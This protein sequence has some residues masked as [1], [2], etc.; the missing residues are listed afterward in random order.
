MN[1]ETMHTLNSQFNQISVPARKFAELSL[2]HVQKLAAFQLDAGRNYLAL[3]LNQARSAVEFNDP[4]GFQTFISGQQKLLQSL[5]Q[6]LGE[7]AQTVAAYN[8]DYAEAAINLTQKSAQDSAAVAAAVTPIKAVQTAVATAA[9]AAP[10]GVAA[11]V[12]TSAAPTVVAS[13]KP[14]AAVSEP[15][16]NPEVVTAPAR[17]AS[18]KSAPKT[19]A[20]AGPKATPK[21]AARSAAKKTV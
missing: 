1:E 16:A 20:K 17:K 8:R 15:V 7:D 12:A 3:A 5:A 10:V 18:A 19:A 14:A 21:A 13:A 11:D 4:K 2:D 9:A 6:R